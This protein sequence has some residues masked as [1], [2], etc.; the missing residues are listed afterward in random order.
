MGEEFPLNGF[1]AT[2]TDEML[3]VPVFAHG[4]DGWPGDHLPAT[5]ATWGELFVIA[6]GMVRPTTFLQK[7]TSANQLTANGA[8]EAV[9]M[10]VLP[11]RLNIAA[12]DCLL[13][14]C[15]HQFCHHSPILS[16]SSPGMRSQF[17]VI[18]QKTSSANPQPGKFLFLISK[19]G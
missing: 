11:H 2:R 17:F 13:T 6:I 19:N 7:T 5:G 18:Q 8:A 12:V 16:P 14:G 3:G 9:G 15:A 4:A 10:P 1:P